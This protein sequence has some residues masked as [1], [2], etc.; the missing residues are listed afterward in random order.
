MDG[1]LEYKESSSGNVTDFL[2][3]DERMEEGN[4]YDWMGT[5]CSLRLCIAIVLFSGFRTCTEKHEVIVTA[6]HA[7]LTYKAGDMI[8]LQPG[9][10]IVHEDGTV[11]FK[12]PIQLTVVGTEDMEWTDRYVDLFLSD[13]L[14]EELTKE[15]PISQISI[16]LSDPSDAKDFAAMLSEE[17]PL[18]RD[19]IHEYQS[20]Y[21]AIQRA[22][23]GTVIMFA[24]LFGL[25]LFFFLTV[26][27]IRIVED[28]KEQESIRTVMRAVGASDHVLYKAHLSQMAV[29]AAVSVICAVA[30]TYSLLLLF[31]NR[32]GYHLVFTFK[33]VLIQILILL[34]S[35]M[36]Y[37]IPV[38]MIFRKN[39]LRRH[40]MNNILSV[41]DLTRRYYQGDTEITAVNHACLEI[42]KGDFAAIVGASGSGKTTL[43]NMLGCID[44]P[45]AGEII[46]GGENVT[47][48]DDDRLA[49][50][51]RQRIGYIYQDFKLLPVLNA[52][53]NIIMPLLLDGKKP[54]RNELVSLAE[55]L[56]I[57]QRLGHLPSELSGV[58]VSGLLLP[59]H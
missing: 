45:T 9:T 1:I 40:C 53:E 21:I 49:K 30:L 20:A 15:L 10:F 34:C 3:A 17:Y 42:A 29:I 33:V 54:D 6:N 19:E 44:R 39:I 56:G 46:L 32:T 22:M 4:H 58:S 35:T 47:E 38:F 16:R 43:L 26:Q 36:T 13:D 52:E 24:I 55:E 28:L 11:S 12:E 50:V 37:F 7:I 18:I 2:I 51:R 25:M 5:P 23:P 57:S 31:F 48:M 8:Q 14:Y 41:K 27:I 59:A